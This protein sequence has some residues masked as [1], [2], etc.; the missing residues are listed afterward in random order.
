MSWHNYGQSEFRIIAGYA[1]AMTHNTTPTST[2]KGTDE[3]ANRLTAMLDRDP[4]DAIRLAREIDISAP[5][6]LD[7]MNI[8]AAILVDGGVATN[9]KDAIVEGLALYRKLYAEVVAPDVAY[10]LANAIAAVVGNPPKDPG[11]LDHQERTRGKRAE[12]RQLYWR[13]ARDKEVDC[14]IRTQAWTNLGNQFTASFRV[15]EAHDARLAAL[16]IDPTNGVAAGAAARD[17]LWLYGLGGCSELTRTEAAMLAKVA[18]T[19]KDRIRDLAGQTASDELSALADQFDDPPTRLPHT[20]PFMRW[21]ERERLTLA[22]TV[23]LIDPTLGKLD[24]LMLPRIMDRDAISNGHQVPTL[25]AMFNV[26][27]ADF[28]L[29]RD[30]AWR[31]MKEDS[32]PST[33]RFNDTLDYA[34]YGPHTSALVFAQRTALDLLDKVAVTANHYFELGHEPKKVAFNRLWR[35][36]KKLTDSAPLA[37]KV[38]DAIRAGAPGLYGLVELSDDYTQ[39]VGILRSHKE[40][41][42]AGTHR[43]IVLHDLGLPSRAKPSTGV[44]HQGHADFT[45]GVLESLRVA[46][47]AIQMITLAITQNE[48]ELARKLDGPV[49]TLFVPDHDSIRG[50]NEGK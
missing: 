37:P 27:K 24:W 36:G 10:N 38:E 48:R 1:V 33:G 11:W 44:S 49:G 29:A 2:V 30:L 7:A 21:L 16:A 35:V 4:A 9:D 14:A 19:H 39:T 8:R 13:V 50:K 46:R 41:R 15:G 6:N 40:L 28:I 20:D 12:A 17:L 34:T 42:D 47:S 43:F 45:V 26:L 32:W 23:E 18:N 31:A 3:T 22:P 5:D 25:F